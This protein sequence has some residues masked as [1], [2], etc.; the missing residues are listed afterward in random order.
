MRSSGTPII[1]STLSAADDRKEITIRSINYN[2]DVESH[3]STRTQ[4][5]SKGD[6][7]RQGGEVNE[8]DSSKHLGIKSICDVTLVVLVATLYVSNH[9]AKWSASTGQGVFGR[10]PCRDGDCGKGT[11]SN[12]L[13]FL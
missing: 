12:K 10:K 6:G 8:D 9:P 3:K 13:D 2:S 7:R 11:M 1:L 5:S 4:Q